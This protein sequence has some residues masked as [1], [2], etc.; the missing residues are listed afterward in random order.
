MISDVDIA[1]AD[2]AGA[3]LRSIV[4]GV[5]PVADSKC[6]DGLK[7]AQRLLTGQKVIGSCGTDTPK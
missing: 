6:S 7:G 5:A 2:L 4:V 1:V 3:S